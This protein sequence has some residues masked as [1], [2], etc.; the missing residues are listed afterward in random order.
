[1]AV[2]ATMAQVRPAGTAG[3]PVGAAD[4]EAALFDGVREFAEAMIA[5]ARS[6][7]ALALEYHK[8]EEKALADGMELMR[9]LTEAHMA[10]RA[11]RE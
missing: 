2:D 11:T 7:K 4:A 8:L 3:G 9:R 10:L 5:W 6:G 1:M